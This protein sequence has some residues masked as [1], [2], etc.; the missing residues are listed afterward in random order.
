MIDKEKHGNTFVCEKVCAGKGVQQM[1]DDF[2]EL[3]FG[4]DEPESVEQSG[5][6]RENFIREHGRFFISYPHKTAEET[7]PAAE[8]KSAVRTEACKEDSGSEQVNPEVI[9]VVEEELSLDE[10]KN[11]QEVSASE[12]KTENI[13]KEGIVPDH[14][15]TVISEDIHSTEEPVGQ[16]EIPV[17][18]LPVHQ[19]EDCEDSPD[20]VDIAEEENLPGEINGEAP[21]EV[22]EISSEEQESPSEESESDIEEQ[23][24]QSEESESDIEEQESQSEKSEPDIKVQ[25]HQSEEL[26]ADIEE[27]ENQLDEDAL[28]I[29]V[30]EI[31]I[32]EEDSEEDFLNEVE[33][34]SAPG[35]IDSF[36]GNVVEIPLPGVEELPDFGSGSLYGEG[37]DTSG[38]EAGLTAIPKEREKIRWYLSLP[39][40][41]CVL[42]VPVLGIAAG[43]VLLYIRYKTYRDDQ[44]TNDLTTV[45]IFLAVCLMILFLAV[46]CIAK[47]FQSSGDDPQ[48][49]THA[50]SDREAAESLAR[51]E[52][53]E[54]E[55]EELEAWIRTSAQ[56]DIGLEEIEFVTKVPAEESGAEPGESQGT[57]SPEESGE[58]WVTEPETG[59]EAESPEGTEGFWSAFLDKLMG[60]SEEQDIEYLN[61][62]EMDLKE[63]SVSGDTCAQYSLTKLASEVTLFTA[64]YDDRFDEE[65]QALFNFMASYHGMQIDN[66][67]FYLKSGLMD[68]FNGT[69]HWDATLDKTIYRYIGTI[70]D[71]M[72][73]GMG[74]VLVASG[75]NPN[76]YIPLHA[77]TFVNGTMEGYGMT[78]RENSGFYGVVYEGYYTGGKYSG[79]GALYDIPSSVNFQNRLSMEDMAGSRYTGE[80][81][82]A[83]LNAYAARYSNALQISQGDGMLYA[84]LNVPVVVPVITERGRYEKGNT[85]GYCIRY[86]SFGIR[87]YAGILKKGVHSGPGISYYENGRIKYDGEWKY[88]NYHGSG[89]LYHEDGSI[90]YEGEFASGDIKSVQQ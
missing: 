51:E 86:G 72:P 57:L 18:E 25:E 11:H 1:K 24:S 12:Q 52:A 68:M 29:E 38:R 55:K 5:T 67:T 58:E 27:Q 53:E 48:E 49:T 43:G 32:G 64:S 46:Y 69:V 41:S 45:Y 62:V 73:Q 37:E 82:S 89:I 81:I 88:G 6:E 75:V 63:L 77:G 84:A 60:N 71:G 42:L 65:R 83:I 78:F 35:T 74:V 44:Q 59:S 61:N 10:V 9:P 39:F 26:A 15:E 54:R 30:R 34:L 33:E 13:R 87:Q 79:R 70:E 47:L 28:Q 17:A 66:Q 56:A 14:T 20:D 80:E 4:E 2:I 19:E 76:T 23:E 85:N 90:W 7:V 50:Q 21:G 31:Y 22:Q 8:D 16:T 36:F 3:D 40:I